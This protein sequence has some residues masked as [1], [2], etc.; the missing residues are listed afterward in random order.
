MTAELERFIDRMSSSYCPE[1][2]GKSLPLDP[3]VLMRG[4]KEGDT[5]TFE[6][7]RCGQFS[8]MKSVDGWIVS[9]TDIPYIM[10]AE[11]NSA[12]LL[13]R[14]DPSQYPD[15]LTA[16]VQRIHLLCETGIDYRGTGN[17]AKAMDCVREALDLTLRSL[18]NGTGDAE[19]D[20]MFG[21][22]HLFF[23][24][25]S[26]GGMPEE[27]VHGYIGRILDILPGIDGT[28]S[29]GILS[30][31]AETVRDREC[32]VRDRI[33][34]EYERLK[35]AEPV[36]PEGA[37]ET[38]SSTYWEGMALIAMLLGRTEDIPVLV[39]RVAEEW[40]PI[41]S[42]PG[43]TEDTL[44]NLMIFLFT[45]FDSIPDDS[46]DG[47]IDSMYTIADACEDRIPM[48]RDTFTMVRYEHRLANGLHPYDRTDDL[49]DMISRYSEPVNA[50]EASMEV[51]CLVHRAQEAEDF[52]D[53]VADMGKAMDI[54]V[55]SRL[56]ESEYVDLVMDMAVRYLDLTSDDK[57]AQRN[58]VSR[59]RKIGITKDKVKAWKK[60]SKRE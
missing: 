56:H 23:T 58:A 29:V 19:D 36:R 60:K 10:N 54:I 16:D 11:T 1:C 27:E 33:V 9:D 28:T 26:E 45:M 59:L 14:F 35:A 37:S 12:T 46:F 53:V 43:V 20:P 5:V 31:C 38:Y 7:P 44:D 8:V 49:D 39:D 13:H 55:S 15:A 41:V 47:I 18:P 25:A 48:L 17:T 21:C 57:E 52:D 4:A 24:I 50:T 6:C 51:K 34:S 40:K 2:G 30:M 42:S 22:I 3:T 32:A